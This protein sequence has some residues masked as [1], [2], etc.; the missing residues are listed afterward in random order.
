MNTT[1]EGVLDGLGFKREYGVAGM[2]S[3]SS[4][5]KHKRRTGIYVLHFA[6]GEVYAGQA[7]NVIRRFS[8][9]A[10]NYSDIEKVSFKPVGRKNLNIEEKSVIHTLEEAGFH[11]RNIIHANYPY[12]TSKFDEVMS[13]EEQETWR[14][15]LEYIDLTGSRIES[16]DIRGKCAHKKNKML[17]MPHSSEIIKLA[18]LY[19]K[20]A[21]PVPIKSEMY[22]WSCS[23]LPGNSSELYTRISIYQQEVFAL[24]VNQDTISASLQVAK[25]PIKMGFGRWLMTPKLLWK[26]GAMPLNFVRYQP[27]GTDQT[28]LDTVGFDNIVRLLNDPHVLEAIRLFNLRLMRKGTNL[29]YKSHCPELADYLLQDMT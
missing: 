15:D 11:L 13:P 17:Q 27:G 9:H 21:I 28:H 26:Y 1:L 22:F 6:N 2:R 8:Q 25:S 3:L 19:V 12:N 16:Q 7:K 5:Y 4:Q 14:S 20:I 24:H 23:C 18:S 29:N 10:K